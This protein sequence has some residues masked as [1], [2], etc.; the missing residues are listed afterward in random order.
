[1]P[2]T[3]GVSTITL[4]VDPPGSIE[5]DVELR[6]DIRD[7]RRLRVDERGGASARGA[8]IPSSSSIASSNRV[9]VSTIPIASTTTTSPLVVAQAGGLGVLDE[10]PRYRQPLLQH[11]EPDERLRLGAL[12][13]LGDTGQGGEQGARR[14]RHGVQKLMTPQASNMRA[15]AK[16]PKAKAQNSLV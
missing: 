11:L 12:A 3:P 8:T 6:L 14:G 13:G 5:H 7:R 15:S 10:P 9:T 1:M 4:A 2:G 16:S